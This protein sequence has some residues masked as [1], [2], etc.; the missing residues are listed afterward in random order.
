MLFFIFISVSAYGDVLILTPENKQARAIAYQIKSKLNGKNVV[1]S[2]DIDSV[3]NPE[4]VITLGSKLLREQSNKL[5]S[6]TLAS[7]VSP[8]EYNSATNLKKLQSEAIYSVVSPDTLL[9]LSYR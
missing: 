1:I 3:K 6:P 7:F 2:D 4:L 5:N 8:S 9:G